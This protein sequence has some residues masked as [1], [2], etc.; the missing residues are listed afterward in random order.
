MYKLNQLGV[1][2]IWQSGERY[3]QDII[4]EIQCKFNFVSTKTFQWC[5]GEVGKNFNKLYTRK[6]KKI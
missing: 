1:F 6:S 4:E 3:A 5:K 2:I